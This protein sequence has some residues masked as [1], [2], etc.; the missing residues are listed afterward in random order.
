MYEARVRKK[1]NASLDSFSVLKVH[2]PPEWPLI[3]LGPRDATR[4]RASVG[5]RSRD[6]HYLRSNFGV[7][8]THNQNFLF[9]FFITLRAHSK[10]QGV[11]DV[12]KT[13]W[14]R[15]AYCEAE[16]WNLGIFEV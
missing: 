5:R 14:Y 3:I 6:M 16:T 12:S 11:V 7:S 1:K 13:N 4:M 10:I 2:A 15:K 8:S 9:F